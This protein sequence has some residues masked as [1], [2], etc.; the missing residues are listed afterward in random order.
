MYLLSTCSGNSISKTRYC[1]VPSGGSCTKVNL[2]WLYLCV[3]LL[4]DVVVYL[5]DE[6]SE[7]IV[8]RC[9]CCSKS[10]KSESESANQGIKYFA[11][12]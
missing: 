6:T 1:G 4:A 10:V 9:F 11:G 8:C 12:I 7:S 2:G 3:L 5:V